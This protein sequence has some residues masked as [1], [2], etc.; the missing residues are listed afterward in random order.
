MAAATKKTPKATTK[1]TPAPAPAAVAQPAP[2]PA[3]LPEL[4]K[5]APAPAAQPAA[6][7]A[8]EKKPRAKP[9]KKFADIDPKA[10]QESKIKILTRNPDG[11][12]R[13]PKVNG[14]APAKRF[15]KY[16]DG[17]T[18]AQAMAAGVTDADVRWDVAHEYIALQ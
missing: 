15:A 12:I 11:S 3:P 6:Q 13:N 2:K 18:V 1:P 17:M 7:A 14:G 5:A 8:P 9:A 4:P 16:A 10:V